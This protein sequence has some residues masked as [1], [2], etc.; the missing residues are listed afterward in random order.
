MK[1]DKNTDYSG[2]ATIIKWGVIGTIGIA[3][4]GGTA[5][6]FINKSAKE[7]KKDDEYSNTTSINNKG[8]IIVASVGAGKTPSAYSLLIH[9]AL[10]ATNWAGIPD[11][12]EEEVYKILK[13]LKTQFEVAIV[14][15]SYENLYANKTLS[16][17]LD[18]DLDD[19]ELPIA[20]NIIA[21]KPIK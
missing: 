15:K 21:S 2:V 3:A 7:N 17:A 5:Y 16:E 9:S 14:S 13:E 20:L 4:M 8:K 19:D 11:T 18:D 12:N 1:N 6:Y 10:K